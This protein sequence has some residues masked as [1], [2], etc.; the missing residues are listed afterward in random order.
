M[1]LK[2]PRSLFSPSPFL[3]SD[4]AIAVDI[5]IALPSHSHLYFEHRVSETGDRT[6]QYYILY[7]VMLSLSIVFDLR[8]KCE[9]EIPFPII[10]HYYI[11]ILLSKKSI[12]FAHI[13]QCLIVL[14]FEERKLFIRPQ[15]SSN[16]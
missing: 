16:V 15:R 3:L 5:P 11:I 7:L 14:K 6:L 8:E 13:F 2:S 1:I 10:Y 4:C 12:N 9:T